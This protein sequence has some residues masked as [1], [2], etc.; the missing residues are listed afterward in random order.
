MWAWAKKQF[1]IPRNRT[2]LQKPPLL[3]VLEKDLGYR[4]GFTD[5]RP[6]WDSLLQLKVCKRHYGSPVYLW[7]AFGERRALKKRLCLDL[8]SKPSSPA[9]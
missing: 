8:G 1:V 9:Y 4:W 6:A 7:V 2:L 3:C 5:S